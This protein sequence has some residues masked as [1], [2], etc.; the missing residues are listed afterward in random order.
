MA[1]LEALD[2]K[3]TREKTDCPEDPDFQDWLDQKEIQVF[4]DYPARTELQERTVCL[5]KMVSLVHLAH[6]D[7][8]EKGVLPDWT[9]SQ[10]C[11]VQRETLVTAS[12][13]NKDPRGIRDA[14]EV[15]ASTARPDCLAKTDSQGSMGRRETPVCPDCLGRR[16]S[17]DYQDSQEP[18]VNPE[19]MD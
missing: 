7:Q 6:L 19:E 10:V 4:P 15:R 2:P 5:E 17:R 9:D 16:G 18:R 13:D 3:E 12:Q 14:M 8:R 1:S 11:Q